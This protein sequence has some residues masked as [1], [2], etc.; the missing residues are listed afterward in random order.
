MIKL[1]ASKKRTRKEIE[2]TKEEETAFKRDMAQY[3]KD[4]KR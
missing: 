4:V 3:F 1:Q 2:E